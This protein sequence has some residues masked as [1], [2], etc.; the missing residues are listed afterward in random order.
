M[1]RRLVVL[2]LTAGCGS[3]QNSGTPDGM[4]PD[5]SID[6][7]RGC[8]LKAQMDEASWPTTGSPVINSC[9]GAGGRLTGSVAMPVSDGIRGRSVASRAAHASTSRAPRRSTAPPA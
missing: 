7:A 8:A 5:G 9:G 3:V 2:A 6:L 4:P 1:P